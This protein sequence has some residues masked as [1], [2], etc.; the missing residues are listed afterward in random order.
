MPASRT[1]TT[2][3]KLFPRLATS[4]RTKRR[5]SPRVAARPALNASGTPENRTLVRARLL[6]MILDNEAARRNDR[7][8][9]A[10]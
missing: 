2:S 3:V 5:A 8:P 9:T 6:H 1:M 4:V 10:S 7:R